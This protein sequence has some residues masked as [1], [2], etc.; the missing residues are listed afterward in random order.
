MCVHKHLISHIVLDVLMMFVMLHLL[1]LLSLCKCILSLFDNGVNV[2]CELGC[3]WMH[4][5]WLSQ[6]IVNRHGYIL[7]IQHFEC[8]LQH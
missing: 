2:L 1:G 5:V 7:T 3:R 6:G 8:R 4:S